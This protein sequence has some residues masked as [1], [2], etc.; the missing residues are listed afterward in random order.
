MLHAAAPR[1]RTVRGFMLLEVLIAL[2][3]FALGVLGL[4]GLQA[5]AVQQSGQAKYRADAT[6]LAN[7]LIGRM[8]VSDRSS[9]AL[10]AAFGSTANGAEY[11]AWKTRVAGVL[12]GTASYPPIVTITRID[13]LPAIVAGATQAA[14]G[15]TASNQVSVTVRWKPP[16]D[17]AADPPR[18]LVI[19]TEIK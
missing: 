4:V 9:A 2:L 12:P 15:L 5:S 7:D 16:S 11:A 6:L 8:W 14:T 3:I 17:A 1:S 18:S 13:P 19:T 10:T